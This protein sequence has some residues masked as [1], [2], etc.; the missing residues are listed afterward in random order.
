PL[1]KAPFDPGRAKGTAYQTGVWVPLIVAGPLVA[2]PDRDV[3]HMVNAT[4]VFRLFGEIAQI[5]VAQALPRGVDAAPMMPYLTN[6]TQE[7]IRDINFTQGGLNIQANGGRNGHCVFFGTSCSH[8]PISKNVCEDNGGTWW[9]VGADDPSVLTPNLEQCWQVNQAI[10]A[11]DPV[12]YS[13]N[14]I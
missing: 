10:Y 11:A 5:D 6:P 14:R 4:D 12:N 13:T 3:E 8:T 9:G 2:N 7:S 1:V